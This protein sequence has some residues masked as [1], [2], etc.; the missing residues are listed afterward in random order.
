MPDAPASLPTV[1]AVGGT[2]LK[3]TTGGARASETVWNDNGP[4]DD[5]G[6]HQ[7]ESLGATGGGCSM[8]FTATPWQ[9][10]VAGFGATGCEGKRLVAD[11]S[12]VGDPHTGFDIYDSYKCGTE[13]EFPRV[14]G[15]WATFGG[16]S[17]S[18]PLIAGLYGLAGGGHGFDVPRL[19]A[20]WP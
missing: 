2:T 5:M 14:E 7:T 10:D 18:T 15:G 3:L 9:T 12:A 11:V 4:L 13:C 20:L 16:T 19:D 6:Y 1:V 17:L 8:L